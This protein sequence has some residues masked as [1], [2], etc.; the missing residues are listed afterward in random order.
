VEV[1][2]GG[3][4]RMHPELVE[5]ATALEAVRA[6]LHHEQADAPVALRRVGLD[7]RDDEVGVDAVRDEGLGPVDDVAVPVA[8]RA[9]A[10]RRE[11]GAHPRLR[12]GHG[13]DE[14]AG[15]DAGQPAL[16]LGLVAEVQ[17]VGQADVVVQR[18]PEAE[19]R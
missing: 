2:L 19:A 5:V 14:L 6:A 15:G 17:E 7:R 8:Q 16:A 11:V 1:Q 3:V 12:H 9:R 13:R 18:Q 10:H 4:L